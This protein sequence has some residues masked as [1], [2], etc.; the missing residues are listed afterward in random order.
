[1]NRPNPKSLAVVL[2]AALFAAYPVLAAPMASGGGGHRGGAPSGGGGYRGG[3]QGGGA[4][5]RGGTAYRGGGYYHG[6]GYRAGGYC[7]GRY[8]GGR[9]Y[10]G[11]YYG[12]P[13]YGGY[14]GWGWA[15]PLG[16]GLGL[17]LSSPYWEGYPAYYGNAYSVAPAY[18]QGEMQPSA[19]PPPTTQVPEGPVADAPTQRPLY[20]N[21]CAA[22][23]AFYPQV[24][25][26]PS[27]WV[28]R[29][30]TNPN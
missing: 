17:A 11:R 26:C 19:P 15:W 2:A 9:Y 8:Y 30:N 28:F 10:G 13:Y 3:A 29:G 22:V 23:T 27:G 5:Y 18:V 25:S 6:G 12:A 1:M 20:L 21:Y 4:A 14:Y 16:V 24:Q 7:G